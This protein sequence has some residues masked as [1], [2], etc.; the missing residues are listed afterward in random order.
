[1][2]I[3]VRSYGRSNRNPANPLNDRIAENHVTPYMSTPTPTPAVQATT[4]AP[5]QPTVK[6]GTLVHSYLDMGI[7]LERKF[8]ALID[9]AIDDKDTLGYNQD[10]CR[11]VLQTAYRNAFEKLGKADKLE[12]DALVAYV[13]EGMKRKGPDISKV[14]VLAFPKTPEAAAELAKAPEEMGLNKRLELARGNATVESLAIEAANKAKGAKPETAQARPTDAAHKP[15]PPISE[16]AAASKLTTT[17]RIQNH[18]IA[19]FTWALS[20]EGATIESVSDIVTGQMAECAALATEA[21]E[22]AAAAAK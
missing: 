19:M 9:Q 14:L 15:Q 4:V 20:L 10:Q 21:A 8:E 3:G 22:K 18:T 1:M 16:T 7:K 17:E 12:G 6:L 2:A 13:A 5:M 11:L